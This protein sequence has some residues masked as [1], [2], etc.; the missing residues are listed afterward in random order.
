MEGEYRQYKDAFLGMAEELCGRM[1]GK[2][3]SPR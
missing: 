2:G 3:G 1:S